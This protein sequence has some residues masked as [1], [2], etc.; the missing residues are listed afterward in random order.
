MSP[1]FRYFDAS[2]IAQHCPAS[3][4]IDALEGAFAR[5]SAPL[6]RQKAPLGADNAMLV[7]PA[8]GENYFGVK[9]VTAYPDNPG[10][11]LPTIQG[12]YG[13]FCRETGAVL[14]L[15]DAAEITARRTAAVS[16]LAAKFLARDDA[17]VLCIA[18]AGKLAPYFAEAHCAA[19]PIKEIRLFARRRDSAVQCARSIAL[20]TRCRIT[21]VDDF[22]RAASECDIISTVTSAQ[23]PF[24]GL[25]D[26]KAGMHLDLVGSHSEAM[27][28]ADPAIL[29]IS[30][31]FVDDRRNALNEAGEIIR[32]MKAGKF[33]AEEIRGDL[34][35]LC[36]RRKVGR[37]SPDEI[38]MFKAVGAGVADLAAA[39]LVLSRKTA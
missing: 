21:I 30:S 17:R 34:G 24:V 37:T 5:E 14:A 13:L 23:T 1:P 31:V 20:K 32:A 38:T 27:C 22:P 3:A 12:F 8:V 25:S 28:E 7:M 19:R 39:T 4:L 11:G 9:A 15:F 26:V 10:R 16:A 2:E 29:G 33:K 6:T 18:G 35:D 36:S